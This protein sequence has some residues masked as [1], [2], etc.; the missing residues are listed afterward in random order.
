MLTSL[1]FQTLGMESV[2]VVVKVNDL[3]FHKDFDII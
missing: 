1:L 3:D 2:N